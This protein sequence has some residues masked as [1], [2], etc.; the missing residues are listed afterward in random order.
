MQDVVLSWHLSAGIHVLISE[1]S[2]QTRIIQTLMVEICEATAS[3]Q[4]KVLENWS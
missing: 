2:M 3:I 4:I 1:K